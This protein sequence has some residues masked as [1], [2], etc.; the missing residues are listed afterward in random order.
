MF[1][2]NY[3]KLKQR[4]RLIV[5]SG[6][7]PDTVYAILSADMPYIMHPITTSP[8]YRSLE[9]SPAESVFLVDLDFVQ[10]MG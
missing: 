1:L 5:F 8:I 10:Y 3:P 6:I 4:N 2:L 7:Y 9:Q